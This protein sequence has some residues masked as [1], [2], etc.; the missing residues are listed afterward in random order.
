MHT[1]CFI[2]IY[3]FSKFGGMTG[4]HSVPVMGWGRGKGMSLFLKKKEPILP[5]SQ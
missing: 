4:T 2:F 1:H 5:L 3:R